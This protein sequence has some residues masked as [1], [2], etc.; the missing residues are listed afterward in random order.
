MI[1]GFNSGGERTKLYYALW[2]WRELAYKRYRKDP[3]AL[4]PVFNYYNNKKWYTKNRHELMISANLF[5]AE[6]VAWG[7]IRLEKFDGTSSRIEKI[8]YE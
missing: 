1:K 2:A 6:A 5:F 7:D 4:I 8:I 3:D